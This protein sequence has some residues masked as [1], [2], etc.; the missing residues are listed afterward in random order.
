MEWQQYRQNNAYNLFVS[1]VLVKV[2]S[3]MD[4]FSPNFFGRPNVFARESAMFKPP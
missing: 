1:D 4:A 2:H 3:S